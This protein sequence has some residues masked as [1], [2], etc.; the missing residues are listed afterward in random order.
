MGRLRDRMK[1]RNGWTEG[2]TVKEEREQ[3]VGRGGWQGRRVFNMHWWL[4]WVAE[5]GWGGRR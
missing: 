2:Q 5:D 1:E 4:G 3:W